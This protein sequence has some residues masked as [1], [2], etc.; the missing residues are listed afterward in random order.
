MDSEPDDVSAFIEAALKNL[1]IEIN[2][3]IDTA[4]VLGLA[5][6]MG[7][8]VVWPRPGDMN[9]RVEIDHSVPVGE[10]RY[11]FDA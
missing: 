3:R 2:Q 5:V 6:G 8:Q 10:I 4:F 7:V 11:A 1:Q 9:V